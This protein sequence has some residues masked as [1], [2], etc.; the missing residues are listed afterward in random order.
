MTDKPADTAAPDKE[1]AAAPAATDTT[2]PAADATKPAADPKAPAGKATAD[3]ATP[4]AEAD[5]GDKVEGDTDGDGDGEGADGTFLDEAEGETEDT[6]DARDGK[7]A[8]DKDKDGKPTPWSE[9]REL[10]VK[11][12]EEK[13]LKKA[14]TDD[15]KKA[16]AARVGRLRQQIVRYGSE[17]SAILAG[18]EAQEKLRSGQVK[19]KPGADAS[20]EE[21][22]EYRKA[23]ELPLEAK[24]VDVRIPNHKWTEQDQPLIGSFQQVV[25]DEEIPQKTITKLV[26]WFHETGNNAMDFQKQAID[27]IDKADKKETREVLKDEFGEEFKPRLD[28]MGRLFKDD[29]VFPGDIGGMIFEARTPDGHKL[30]NNAEFVKFF[31]EVALDRYGDAGF[32]SGDAKAGNA[33]VVEQARKVMKTDI[34]KYYAEGWDK[35]LTAA[36]EKSAGTSKRGRAA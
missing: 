14:K 11:T 20:P 32:I 2:K 30:I 19:Q 24:D 8:A 1:T 18:M 4:A 34:D 26:N 25:F 6:T 28:L 29:E 10:I 35:K 22:A 23:N 12:A 17:E 31:A 21:I 13:W 3:K 9:R 7:E 33:S 27:A 36:L 15:E 16:V 5:K